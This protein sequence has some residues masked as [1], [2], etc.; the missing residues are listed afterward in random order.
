MEDK[1]TLKRNFVGYID[2]SQ[3]TVDITD[4]GYSRDVW[5][6]RTEEIMPGTYSCYAYIGDDSVWGRRVWINQ[7]VIADGDESHYAE[8][9]V[10]DEDAWEEIGEIGVDAGM[11]GFFQNKPDFGF[12]DWDHLCAWLFD[13][14]AKH[15]S[16]GVEDAYIKN[17]E[18]GDGFWTE[19][20]CGDGCYGVY[21]IKKDDKIVALEIRF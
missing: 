20:G 8:D 12:D 16:E 4:P 9:L 1:I 13:K 15:N 14:A 10:S 21:A 5:C 6:R 2:L 17:F 11:A 7:I 3:G 18:T 19:S